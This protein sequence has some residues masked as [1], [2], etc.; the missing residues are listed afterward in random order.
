MSDCIFC[1]IVAGEIPA[2]EVARTAGAVA[3]HDQNPQAPV[4]VLVVPS[5]HV[6]NAAATD[7]DEGERVM[8]ATLRLAVQVAHQLGLRDKGYRLVLN[9]GPDGGQSVGHLHVHV[10]GGRGM[11]WPPG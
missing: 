11:K 6:D 1:R 2:K 3:F 5:R 7:S 4:H 8:G 10:L 9:T